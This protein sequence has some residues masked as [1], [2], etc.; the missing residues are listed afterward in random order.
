MKKAGLEFEVPSGWELECLGSLSGIQQGLSKGKIYK[1][2]NTVFHPYLRVANVKDGYFDLSEIKEIEIPT[3]DLERYSILENDILITEGGDP[4]KLGRGCIWEG[5]ISKPVFQN[6]VFRIRASNSK[7]NPWYLFNYLQSH[8]AKTYFLNSAKQTTGIASINSSQVKETPILLPPLVEQKKIAEILGAIDQVI[9]TFEKLIAQKELRKKWLMQN[10][11]N[12]KKRLKGFSG[13]WREFQLLDLFNRVTRK[14]E[15]RNSNV[16]TISAQRGFV[17]QKD[18]FKKNIASE[19]LDNYFLVYRGEFCYNKSYSNGYPW[20]ATK[21]LNDFD[22]AVV[23]TLYIC[24][25]IKNEGSA[26]PDFF[27]QFFNANLLDKGLVKI[28]H[29]G[30]RAHG[31]LNVTQSDFFSLKISI[32][33]MKEQTAIAQVLQTADFEINLLKTKAEKLREQKKGMMQVL[34]TGKRRIWIDE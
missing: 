21:R 6:H 27:E 30:G 2:V 7:L 5:Q 18:F 14:N 31:L 3:S 4:D 12:G 28:A 17:K 9:Q 16:V 22:K 20:G 34:L 19:I 32:P 11:L 8:K 10:L 23:T 29:E 24:F 15:E 33:E 25:G 26:D 1:N 13:E